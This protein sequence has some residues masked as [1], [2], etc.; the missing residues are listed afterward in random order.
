MTTLSRRMRNEKA[1]F[2][3]LQQAAEQLNWQEELYELQEL[4]QTAEAKTFLSLLW[5]ATRPESPA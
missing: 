1:D 5:A 4:E 2:E 3:Q